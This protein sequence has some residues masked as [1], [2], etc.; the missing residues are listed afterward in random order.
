MGTQAQ[1]AG[2]QNRANQP[3]TPG[4]DPEQ[5]P[6]DLPTPRGGQD[7]GKDKTK[8]KEGFGHIGNKD[9]P[10]SKGTPEPQDNIF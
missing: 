4:G 7:K 6:K 8:N 10:T 2:N 3:P 5:A 9:V 1:D